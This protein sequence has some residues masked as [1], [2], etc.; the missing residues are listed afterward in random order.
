MS[1]RGR[2]SHK[3]RWHGKAVTGNDAAP[4]V[5]V[6]AQVLYDFWID[7]RAERADRIKAPEDISRA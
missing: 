6:E 2:G 3:G 7:T 5:P 1:D 4:R